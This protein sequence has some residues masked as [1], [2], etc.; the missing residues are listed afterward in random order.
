MGD[1]CQRINKTE[2]SEHTD[3]IGYQSSIQRMLE[4]D[5]SDG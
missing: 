2:Q 3:S 5:T 1:T 4:K